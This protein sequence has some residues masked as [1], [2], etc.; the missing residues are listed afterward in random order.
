V[1]A[2]SLVCPYTEY[3]TTNSGMH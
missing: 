2:R 1:T 3:L